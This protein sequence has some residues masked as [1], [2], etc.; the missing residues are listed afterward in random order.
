MKEFEVYLVKQTLLDNKITWKTTLKYSIQ[1]QA[2]R[3]IKN[4]GCQHR[5]NVRNRF[6]FEDTYL[7]T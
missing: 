6:I 3:N 2:K 1:I 7:V 5:Q 4:A